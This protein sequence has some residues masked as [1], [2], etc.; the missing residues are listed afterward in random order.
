MPNYYT[1]NPNMVKSIEMMMTNDMTVIRNI[2][3]YINKYFKY[4]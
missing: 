2:A 3:T 1:S 4:L